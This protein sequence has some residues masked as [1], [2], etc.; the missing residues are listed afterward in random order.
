MSKRKKLRTSGEGVRP[1]KP[2]K[3]PRLGPSKGGPESPDSGHLHHPEESEDSSGP[4]AFPELTGEEPRGAVSSSPHEET[5]AASRLLRQPEKEP[6]PLPPSQNSVGRFVPQFAKPRKTGTRKAETREEDAENGAVSSD[7]LPVPSA[8]QAGSLLLP[9]SLGLALQEARGPGEQTQADSPSTEQ[10]GQNLE[11]SVPGRGDSQPLFSPEVGTG[12]SHPERASQNRLLEQSNSVMAGGNLGNSRPETEMAWVPGDRGQKGHLPGSDAGGQGSDRGAPRGGGAQ[13]RSGAE[14]PPVPKDEGASRPHTAAPAPAVGLAQE[15]SPATPHLKTWSVGQDLPDPRQIPGGSGGEAGQSH[16]SP[17][18]TSLSVDP[19]E[20]DQRTPEVAGPGG[21]AFP[22]RQA[23][24]RGCSAAKLD[25]AP[26]AEDTTAGRGD[27]GL[28]GGP[29]GDMPSS[30][31][32][33]LAPA[34]GNQTSTVCAKDSGHLAL[35]MGPDVG[36]VPRPSPVQEGPGRMC[37]QPVDRRAAGLGSQGR[38]QVLKE[39]SLSPGASGLLELRDTVGDPPPETGAPLG[40][41]EPS[42][43]AAGQ[44]QQ[45]PTSSDLEVGFLPDSQIREAL[46]GASFEAPPEQVSPAGSESGLCWPD[47]SPRARGDLVMMAQVQPR[48]GVGVQA[49][50]APRMEDATGTVQGLVV[51]LSNLNRL[52]MSAHRDLEAFRRLHSRKAKPP[53]KAPSLYP[54]KGSLS[55]GEQ[56]WRDL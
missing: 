56:A 32:G 50:E 4:A 24:G 53:G 15:L 18:C 11:I 28:E 7:T 10:S 13:G 43:E 29:Q 14:L 16:S 41:P 38:E 19:T 23:P 46:E 55:R 42:V 22:S 3:N 54:P 33:F 39:L 20:V 51:E 8:Q 37:T 45:P 21:Q 26:L 44:P 49:P 52:I 12:P 25:C 36:Q 35:E 31:L 6:T 30:P 5:G 1:P 9:E 27:L 34:S 40:S 17:G 47:P 48:P 2:P